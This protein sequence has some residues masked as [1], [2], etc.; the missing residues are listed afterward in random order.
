MK[1][2]KSNESCK[3]KICLFD[4]CNVEAK[5]KGYC[6]K[7]YMQLRR[8]GEIK[9][10]KKS[11]MCSVDGC[12]LPSKNRCLC[13]MHYLRYMRHG[14][15]NYGEDLYTGCKVDG[16]EGKYHAKG[17]CLKHYRLFSRNG[18]PENVRDM[19]GFTHTPEY[20][21]WRAMIQRCEDE[22]SSNYHR[23]GG[24]G[25]SVCDKWRHS[26]PEFI[27][28]VGWRP[29]KIHQIDR[30]D[31][32]GNYEPSNCRWVTPTVNARNSTNTKLSIEKAN[33]IRELSLNGMTF[34]DIAK[35][36]NVAA[37]TISAVVHNKRWNS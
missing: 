10:K 32:D 13:N 4:G 24:R 34:A 26:F 6:K 7:H 31:N 19:H 23:Y 30:I 27:S 21:V 1:Y 5:C 28:D 15:V 35:I 2:E 14:D 8:S 9:S 22:K 37:S 20:K 36:Y 33:Q 16:C 29:S 12:N 18:I 3:G 11:A 17:Y 25:I